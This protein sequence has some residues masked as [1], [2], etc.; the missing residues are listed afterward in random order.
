MSDEPVN[1]EE[2]PQALP[3]GPTSLT[4]LQK[5]HA[6]GHRFYYGVVWEP[7]TGHFYTTS[8]PDLE[9]YQIVD[10]TEENVYTRY[11]DP[12]KDRGT[13]AAWKRKDFLDPNSFGHARVWVPEWVFTQVRDVAPFIKDNPEWDATDFAHPA[14]WRGEQHA[15][16]QVVK[17]IEEILDG[18]PVTG[19][20]GYA[21]LQ[22]VRKRV[23]ALVVAAKGEGGQG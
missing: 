3:T 4:P 15:V 11:C 13:V 6:L 17:Q 1:V 5:L 2:V 19:F 8:R 20:S 10:V 21:P 14:W 22:A 23:E 12:A 9:L 7:K 18:K 16:T